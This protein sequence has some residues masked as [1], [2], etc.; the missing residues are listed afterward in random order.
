MNQNQRQTLSWAL[1]FTLMAFV[2]YYF[3]LIAVNVSNDF[4]EYTALSDRLRGEPLNKSFQR[5][6]TEPFYLLMFWFMS[7]SF[8]SKTVVILVGFIPLLFKSIII[9]KYS[10]YPFIGLIFYFGTFLSLHDANQIRLAAACIFMLYALMLN[11]NI[12][13]TKLFF[14]SL[15]A[16]AF[17]YT[18]ILLL[19]LYLKIESI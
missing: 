17:H 2:S 8:S 19:I 18:G 16:T 13:K 6:L 10:Y 5:E 4:S 11:E 12:S 3:V 14:L 15:A 1:F 7:N 9:K